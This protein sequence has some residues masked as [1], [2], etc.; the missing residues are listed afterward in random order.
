MHV[1]FPVLFPRRY[2]AAGK[3]V[4]YPYDDATTAEAFHARFT[5]RSLMI[6]VVIAAG[7]LDA[8]LH[9]ERGFYRDGLPSR[10]LRL[11]SWPARSGFPKALGDLVLGR[12]DTVQPDIRRS[13]HLSD[14]VRSHGTRY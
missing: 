2:P 8:P 1:L 6:A 7:L 9:L 3:P 10:R 11:R 4:N 5:I 12:G 14:F 13:L